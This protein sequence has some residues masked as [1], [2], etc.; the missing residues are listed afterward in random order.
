M[1]IK[2]LYFA[3]LIVTLLIGK[4]LMAQGEAAVPFL[5]LAPDARSGSLGESGAGLA[6]NSAAIFWNPAGIAFLTGSEVSITHSNWLP[7]FHLDI[8]YDY[9]TFRMYMPELRG[10]VTAS[11]TY[12]DYGEF[13]RTAS[14]SPD[15]I[16]TFRSFDAA[17]TVGYATKVLPSLGLGGN[18]RIIHSHLADKPTELETG[19]GYATTVS[20]DVAMMWRPVKL[21][22]PY[23]GDAGNKFS[24]GVN[25]SNIGPK[26][27]Y[28]DKAQ[29][30]PIPT[31]LRVGLAYRILDIDYN[32]LTWTG[33]MSKLL[34][35]RNT[36]GTSEDVLKFYKAFA[37][38]AFFKKLIFSSGLE[39]MYGTPGDF[40][41]AVRTGIFYEDPNYGARKFATFGA[42]LKYDMYGFDFSYISTAIFS[43]QENHPLSE[44]LRFSLSLNWG[45]VPQKTKGLP[46]GI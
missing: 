45:A 13:I 7:Q 32:S 21:V 11:I 29:A 28:I 42:G 41:F 30:D 2:R 43:G 8:F 33:D 39:Y 9:L 34:V 23:L 37:D 17:L 31:N 27:Y 26:I 5:L 4:N 1:T 44:T 6:D 24:L 16:G 38:K 14:N 15:P 3:I 18:F 10:S 20:F 19:T 12:M 40:Q 46:R 25:I 36:D 22:I 35:T